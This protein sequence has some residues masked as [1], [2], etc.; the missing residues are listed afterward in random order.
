[1]ANT[2]KNT[3]KTRRIA[4]LAADGVDAVSLNKMKQALEAAGAKS[5]IIA[6][7]LGN[8]TDEKDKQI[9]VDQ[10]LLTAAS[11]LFD[12]VYIPGG[13]KSAAALQKEPNAIHFIN[14]AYKHCKVIA[15]EGEGTKL[16]FITNAGIK[17]NSK[18]K[19]AKNH[20]ANGVLLNRNS[21]EFIKAVAQHR[22]WEREN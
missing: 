1:M 18:D 7:H 4:I 10:S 14:E 22:F 11:V 9:K 12:A 5:T 3:I 13:Q 17:I 15:A 2:V 16:L 19:T 6:P 8:I 21:K 20:I